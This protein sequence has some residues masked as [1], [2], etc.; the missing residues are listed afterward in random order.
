MSTKNFIVKYK[1]EIEKITGKIRSYIFLQNGVYKINTFK[2][3]F[4]LK[5][6]RKWDKSDP[7][8]LRIQSIMSTAFKKEAMF[9]IHSDNNFKHLK[10]QE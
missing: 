6:R 2:E 8:L 7:F 9:Y 3:S 1:H 4:I 5:T 10:L